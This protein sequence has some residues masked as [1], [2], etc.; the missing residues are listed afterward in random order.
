MGCIWR[1]ERRDGP[2]HARAPWYLCA[3]TL[4]E[5]VDGYLPEGDHH[6]SELEFVQRFVDLTE[7][8]RVIYEGYGR[9]RRALLDAG[10]AAEARCLLNGSYT[11][12]KPDPGDIDLAVGIEPGNAASPD[13]RA[14]LS[15]PDA[16]EAFR[17]DAYPVVEYPEGHPHHEVATQRAWAYWRN[18]FG[19]DR[20]G[21]P[22]G[23]VWATVGGF[24]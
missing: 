18:C 21:R 19:R 9:H 12:S 1:L 6:P 7:P 3:V 23:R 8:R 2:P 15:G 5:F 17:C 4:P 16:K 11:T 13:V 14:L 10:V 24:R 22:K 20:S